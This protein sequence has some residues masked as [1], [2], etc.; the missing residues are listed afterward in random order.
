MKKLLAVTI[1]IC[2]LSVFS[3]NAQFGIQIG[4]VA[5]THEAFAPYDSLE[6]VS[7]AVGYTFGVF[8]KHWLTD[9][10]SLQ[11]GLN[12]VSKR[13]WE[14]LDDGVAIYVTRVSMNYLELPIQVVYTSKK[15][16]GIFVGA[17][18]SLMVGLGGKRTVTEDGNL[19]ESDKITIGSVNAPEKR[20][21]IAVNTMAG[22]AFKRVLTSLNY[23]QGITNQPA[24][25]ADHGNVNQLTLRVS[26]LFGQQ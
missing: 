5:S 26:F 12:L 3:A 11:P 6:K 19:I 16:R 7:G 8:Y 17:G 18:P 13:W 23:S 9:Y 1:L 15:T 10:I 4:G 20:M 25:N 21:T 24:N 22:Y 2:S 14:E